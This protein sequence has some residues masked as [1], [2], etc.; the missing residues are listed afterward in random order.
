[1]A[2]RGFFEAP[3]S[4]PPTTNSPFRSCHSLSGTD[5]PIFHSP[6]SSPDIERMQTENSASNEI[7]PLIPHE[8][9]YGRAD[10]QREMSMSIVFPGSSSNSFEAEAVPFWKHIRYAFLL[11]Y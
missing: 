5:S 3:N 11:L 7:T 6:P 1:M 8:N 4:S 2:S 9:H 10:D